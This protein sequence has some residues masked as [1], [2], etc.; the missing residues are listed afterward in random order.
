MCVSAVSYGMA[1]FIKKKKLFGAYFKNILFL[2]SRFNLKILI[3]I[4]VLIKYCVPN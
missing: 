2:F 1:E 3:V 4:Y